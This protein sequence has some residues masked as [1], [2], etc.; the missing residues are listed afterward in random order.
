MDDSLELDKYVAN[1]AKKGK[2]RYF[3]EKDLINDGYDEA[4]IQR[5]LKYAATQKKEYGKKM[6]ITGSILFISSIVLLVTNIRMPSLLFLGGF[7][8]STFMIYD[9]YIKIK[10]HNK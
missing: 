9:G 4:Q 8:S 6:L 5:A 2:K 10:N 1:L 3:I 7:L